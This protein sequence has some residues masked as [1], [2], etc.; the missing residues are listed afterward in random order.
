MSTAILTRIEPDNGV[1]TLGSLIAYNSMGDKF[2]CSTLELPWKNNQHDIS[3]IQKG[4]YKCIL[5]PFH[6][7][8]RYELQNV[9]QRFAI[10]IHDGN[11]YKDVL[12]CILLGV[13]PTD[14][15]GDGQIDVTS[16]FM[17]NQQFVTFMGGQPFTLTIQ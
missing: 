16:S 9:P 14:I 2:T 7:M 17:T 1:E 8:Q 5:S 15:N 4:V 10:F 3:C 6:N 13:K 12:G 11:Y